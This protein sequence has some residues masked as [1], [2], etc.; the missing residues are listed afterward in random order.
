MARGPHYSVYPPI[1]M[2]GGSEQS[3]LSVKL[4]GMSIPSEG[5]KV[6]PMNAQD[7]LRQAAAKDR[8]EV[9]EKLARDMRQRIAARG[10]CEVTLV[11]LSQARFGQPHPMHPWSSS[12]FTWLSGF[13]NRHGVQLAR[14]TILAS[15]DRLRF[16]LKTND[17]RLY[18]I[19][20]GKPAYATD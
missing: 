11:V 17:D 14:Q 20:P 1:C 5:A 12:F 2:G 4:S 10:Y 18:T 9:E 13:C 7:L 19:A 16:I 3:P 8:C 15:T 6:N